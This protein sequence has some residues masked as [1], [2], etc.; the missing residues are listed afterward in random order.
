MKMHGNKYEIRFEK[1]RFLSIFGD[2]LAQTTQVHWRFCSA[3]KKPGLL[4]KVH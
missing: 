4:Y 3:M 1:W 2:F